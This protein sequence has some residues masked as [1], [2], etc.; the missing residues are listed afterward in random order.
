MRIRS[1]DTLEE[2]RTLDRLL[3][4][5]IRFVTD[6]LQRA[7]GVSF[8]AETLLTKTKA[9]L[10]KVIP[11]HGTTLV[12]EDDSSARL[13]MCFLRPSGPTAMER[14]RLYVPPPGRGQGAGKAL[15]EKSIEVARGKGADALRLD[16]TRNLEAAIGLYQALGFEE[17]TPYEESDHFEDPVLGP[18]LIFMEKRL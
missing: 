12:A 7:S 4:E 17:R 18:Y 6:D 5:Y 14:K 13:G 16:S 9:S 10:E 1:L 11:P 3:E 2:V 15:V 8:D